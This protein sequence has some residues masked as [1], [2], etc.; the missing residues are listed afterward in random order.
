MCSS[1]ILPNPLLTLP[2]TS[3]TCR[4]N[5]EELAEHAAPASFW[6]IVRFAREERLWLLLGLGCTL[7]RG[8]VWPAFAIIYGNL[9]HTLA[10]ALRSGA[11]AEVERMNRNMALS[12]GTLGL[13]GGLFTFL[14]GLL[15]GFTGEKV[16]MRMRLA[17]FK[18]CAIWV[19]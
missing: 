12:Y 5:R 18:V 19:L 6:Q 1:L 8:C 17:V 16:T 10:Q 3:P 2:T 15:L 11:S 4:R 9:F 13:V 14:A 7:V